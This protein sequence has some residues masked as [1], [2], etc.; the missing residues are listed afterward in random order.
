MKKGDFVFTSEAMTEGHPDKVC[1]QI[2]DAILDEIIKKDP[3]SRVACE[4]MVGMGFVIITGEISTRTSINYSQIARKV[5]SDIGYD[6][7]EY[8]FD[9]NT[10]GVL[11]SIHEQS[12]DIAMGV[13]GQESGAGDQGMMSGYATNETPEFMP[14]PI[15]LAQKLAKKLTE[16]RKNGEI[17]YLRPD[18]KTQ[19]SV[20]Y[21]R[22]IPKYITSV[23]V[24]TQHD[25]DVKTER[26]KKD[27]KEKL[28]KPVC[29]NWLND[30]TKYYIN[31]TGRFVI[32]GPVADAG[33]TGRKIIA[34]TYGGTGGHGGGAFSGKD[35]TKVDRS[36]AYMARYIA[37]NLVASGICE[38][39]EI[40]LSYA[41]G[42]RKPT[43]VMIDTFGTE[44]IENKKITEIVNSH[45]NLT[46]SGIIKQLDLMKP[47]YRKTSCYGHFGREGPEFTWE[48]T[49]LAEKL[50]K[51][52][53]LY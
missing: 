44:K 39:C 11:T 6:R 12:A 35:P 27:I 41:I 49:D 28:I 48:K 50:K 30:S 2:S 26:I 7:P 23:V 53:G 21:E 1:D 37:K 46:P 20:K 31:N 52:A 8:G 16:L 25:T 3:E 40:Q 42:G 18:G 10:V 29:C 4:A 45:F 24:A 51:E 22:G 13:D 38:K 5:I 19:V 43:S 32:G 36:A 34:D 9:Y 47:V 14:L 33:M 15:L 17:K